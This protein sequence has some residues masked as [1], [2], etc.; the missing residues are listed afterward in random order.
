MLMAAQRCG[1][2]SRAVQV[3][4][5]SIDRILLYRAPHLAFKTLVGRAL[6]FFRRAAKGADSVLARAVARE[7]QYI[8]GAIRILFSYAP[9][10]NDSAPPVALS[11]GMCTVLGIIRTLPRIAEDAACVENSYPRAF[12]ACSGHSIKYNLPMS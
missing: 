5:E 2:G 3:A 7:C 10:V 8:C 4:L 11:V 6:E 9:N 12:G 1:A